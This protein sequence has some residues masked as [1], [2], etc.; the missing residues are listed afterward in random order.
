MV[1]PRIDHPTGC[2]PIV[3]RLGAKVAEIVMVRPPVKQPSLARRYARSRTM[4]IPCPTPI[5]IDAS[6]QR[7]LVAASS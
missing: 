6:P 3:V 2:T 5:H 1:D 4:A 7:P